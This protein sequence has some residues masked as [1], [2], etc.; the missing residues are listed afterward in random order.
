MK[1]IIPL[2]ILLTLS[3]CVS[4]DEYDNLKE[5]Y[6]QAIAN[7]NQCQQQ[8]KPLKNEIKSCQRYLKLYRNNQETYKKST[9]KGFE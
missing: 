5:D 2:L 1:I 6:N 3:A 4:Q 8:A 7:K 9:N